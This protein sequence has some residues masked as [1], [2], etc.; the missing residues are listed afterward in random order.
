MPN[1]KEKSLTSPSPSL[2][3]RIIGEPVSNNMRQSWPE[4]ERSF[5]GRELE[6]PQEASK[7]SKV[8]NMGPFTRWRNPDAYAVTGPMGSIALNRELIEKEKQN[9]DDVL[10]HELAHVGQGKKGFLRKFFNPSAVENEAVNRE[11]LRKVRREDIR[12]PSTGLVD[13]TI[14]KRIQNNRNQTL[15]SK[16]KLKPQKGL[17]QRFFG[18]EE[19]EPPR[20]ITGVRG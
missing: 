9:L 12:L 20:R 16:S 4:L 13:P 14:A 5:A 11:A 18:Q 3:R 10:V 7:V 15:Q 17:F 6:M 2:L 8:I 19:L 1:A